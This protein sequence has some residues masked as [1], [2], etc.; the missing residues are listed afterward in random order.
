MMADAYDNYF[1]VL[2]N[3]CGAVSLYKQRYVILA[4]EQADDIFGSQRKF[5]AAITSV[6]HGVKTNRIH[7]VIMKLR[8]LLLCRLSP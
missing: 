1:N 3:R 5:F 7:E 8:A 2:R 6:R 4:T